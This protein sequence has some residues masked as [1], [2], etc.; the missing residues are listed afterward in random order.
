VGGGIEFKFNR[1]LDGPDPSARLIFKLA[2]LLPHLVE[3]TNKLIE[4]CAF[5]DSPLCS[6]STKTGILFKFFTLG[7]LPLSPSLALNHGPFDYDKI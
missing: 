5:L 3:D 6:I 7:V 4:L 1:E 2:S